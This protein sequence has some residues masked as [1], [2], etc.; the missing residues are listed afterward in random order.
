MIRTILLSR[1]ATSHHGETRKTTL[2]QPHVTRQEKESPQP[3]RLM[4]VGNA[5]KSVALYGELPIRI[6]RSGNEPGF[7]KKGIESYLVPLYDKPAPRC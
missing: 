6:R 3:G 7:L 2:S 1:D 4:S 5:Q